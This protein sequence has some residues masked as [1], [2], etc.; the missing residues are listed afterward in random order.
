M[1]RIEF[2][3]A[4]KFSQ[5]NLFKYSQSFLTF[6]LNW[7]NLLSGF[8]QKAP[9]SS[10]NCLIFLDLCGNSSSIIC[11]GLVQHDFFIS[12][13]FWRSI[14][15]YGLSIQRFWSII[16]FSFSFTS[17][18]SSCLIWIGFLYFSCNTGFSGGGAA[19]LGGGLNI[20]GGGAT[21][22]YINWLISALKNWVVST[23]GWFIKFYW[24]S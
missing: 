2:Q 8:Y 11:K 16:H 14:Y 19:R 12:K 24:C 18:I 22:G 21:Y 1:F 3:I 10:L 20:R 7:L 13:N 4:L 23:N 15:Q 5:V 9:I 6:S 17:S